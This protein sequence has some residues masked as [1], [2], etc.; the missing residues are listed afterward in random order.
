VVVLEKLPLNANGKVDRNALPAPE[1]VEQAST[2]PM[3]APRTPVEGML[4]GIWAE[5]L[6][7]PAISVEDNFFHLGG[8]SL[9]ATQVVSRIREQFNVDLDLRSL[10][11]APTVAGLAK[12]IET[13]QQAPE[14]ISETTILRASRDEFRV[15]RSRS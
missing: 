2:R 13:A 12:L 14:T 6:R 10:F 4:A 15:T 8:H 5:V 9:M 1:D 3:V 7:Q 11:E